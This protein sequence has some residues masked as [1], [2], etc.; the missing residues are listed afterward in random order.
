MYSLLFY[1]FIDFSACISRALVLITGE[2]SKT[3]S[4]CRTDVDVDIEDVLVQAMCLY[5]SFSS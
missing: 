5:A 4:G 2:F 1:P 3:S